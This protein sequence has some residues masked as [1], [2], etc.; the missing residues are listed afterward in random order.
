MNLGTQSS[1]SLQIDEL[2]SA[3]LPAINVTKL[4]PDL[5][6]LT[7]KELQS[8]AKE[9]SISVPAGT[10]RKDLIELLK[11]ANVTPGE[12]STQEGTALEVSSEGTQGLQGTLLASFDGSASSVQGAPLDA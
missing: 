8:L 9:H 1:R 12:V 11:K 5:T 6:S 3:P 4:S 10:R 2:G 7:V